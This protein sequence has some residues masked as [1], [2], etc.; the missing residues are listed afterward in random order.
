MTCRNANGANILFPLLYGLSICLKVEF[1]VTVCGSYRISLISRKVVEKTLFFRTWY[2]YRYFS[3]LSR[4]N[5]KRENWKLHHAGI[6]WIFPEVAAAWQE[7]DMFSF[8][9]IP[10]FKRYRGGADRYRLYDHEFPSREYNL[11]GGHVTMFY[12]CIQSFSIF[13]TEWIIDEQCQSQFFLIINNYQAILNWIRSFWSWFE[14][15]YL[16]ICTGIWLWL[17]INWLALSNKDQWI[18][19]ANNLYI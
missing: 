8:G 1:I 11:S 10:T 18:N 7:C 14:Y 2:W 5:T 13:L 9:E 16:R 6:P 15:D 4:R 12:S 17:S 19:L 3:F